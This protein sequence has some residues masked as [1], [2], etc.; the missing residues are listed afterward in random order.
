MYNIKCHLIIISKSAL[1]Y[2]VCHVFIEV[3]R[4]EVSLSKEFRRV[5]DFKSSSDF[6]K[7]KS[8]LGHKGDKVNW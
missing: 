5:L 3:K 4:I 6:L 7:L 8:N 2:F 1:F